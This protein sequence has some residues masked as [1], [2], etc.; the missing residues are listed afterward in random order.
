MTQ[1]KYRMGYYE[2]E[3]FSRTKIELIYQR[4]NLALDYIP[5]TANFGKVLPHKQE[6]IFA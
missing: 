6:G 1:Q 3:C 4:F 5:K 2:V